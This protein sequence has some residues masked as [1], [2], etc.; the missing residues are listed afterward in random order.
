MFGGF[1][2]CV[3]HQQRGFQFFIQG[4]VNLSARKNRSQTATSFFEPCLE[5]AKPGLPTG[6]GWRVRTGLRI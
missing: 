3:G 2:A 4:L 1:D 6:V 5:F